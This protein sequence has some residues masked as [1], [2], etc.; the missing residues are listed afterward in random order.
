MLNYIMIETEFLPLKN[1]LTINHGQLAFEDYVRLLQ[2][3]NVLCYIHLDAT[4]HHKS[5]ELLAFQK[6]II[7]VPHEH[8]EAILLANQANIDLF[9]C[10]DINA[11]MKALQQCFLTHSQQNANKAF[12]NQL[13]WD[14]QA[15]QLTEYFIQILS[16]QTMPIEK[17]ACQRST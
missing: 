3:A 17:A 9:Q 15:R 4:F 16:N 1:L 12:L 7:C 10:E 2:Q 5:T 11:V 14:A 13:T 6:P 8:E